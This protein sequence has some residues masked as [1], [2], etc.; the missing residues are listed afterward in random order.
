M[1]PLWWPIQ[2]GQCTSWSAMLEVFPFHWPLQWRFNL[3]SS[4]HPSFFFSLYFENIQIYTS[5]QGDGLGARFRKSSLPYKGFDPHWLTCISLI[6]TEILFSC[7]KLN[8]HAGINLSYIKSLFIHFGISS[9]LISARACVVFGTFFA[10]RPSHKQETDPSFLPF[11]WDVYTT[12][13]QPSNPL[14]PK[15]KHI[16][17]D[18]LSRVATGTHWCTWFLRGH[19]SI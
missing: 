5:T 10:R 16:W 6:L 3:N 15:I 4:P 9:T 8:K 13:C 14:M 19:L 12:S 18:H 1:Q 11:E 2:C 17:F 7:I